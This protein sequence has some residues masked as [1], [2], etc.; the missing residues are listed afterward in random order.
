MLY[1]PFWTVRSS[2]V[3]DNA[4]NAC[5]RDEV[6]LRFVAPVERDLHAWA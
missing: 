2:L 4:S 3:T 6:R 5:E 1:Q